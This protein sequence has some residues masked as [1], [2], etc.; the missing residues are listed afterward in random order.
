MRQVI[1]NDRIIQVSD[2]PENIISE[3][4]GYALSLK[5]F[6]LSF[7]EMLEN[8][9][10]G[11]KGIAVPDLFSAWECNDESRS[12]MEVTIWPLHFIPR[13]VGEKSIGEDVWILYRYNFGTRLEA[14]TMIHGKE[15]RN[16]IKI[17]FE[18]RSEGLQ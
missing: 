13:T 14:S 5:A 3:F 6:N 17:A 15:L 10:T 16:L 9:K 11:G 4:L 12:E 8:F 1:E 18:I 7:D 2:D